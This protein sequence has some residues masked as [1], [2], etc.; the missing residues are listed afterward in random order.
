MQHI[1]GTLRT[2]C[3]RHQRRG[4]GVRTTECRL[5]DSCNAWLVL[6]V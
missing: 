2:L 5:T 1:C 4:G 3:R 6:A